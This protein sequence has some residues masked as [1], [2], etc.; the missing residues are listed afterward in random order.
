MQVAKT[1]TLSPAEFPHLCLAP[2]GDVNGA[3]LTVKPCDEDSVVFKYSTK[4]GKL[5][6]TNNKLCID[7]KDGEK[8]NGT[9]AQLWGCYTCNKNQVFD[10]HG[11]TANNTV[12][13]TGSDYC[14]DLT[15]GEGCEG[16]P[17]QLWRCV[18]GNTNQIWTVTEVHEEKCEDEASSGAAET[19][20]AAA[21]EEPAPAPEVTARRRH[22]K[23]TARRH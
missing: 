16:T 4:S 1:Y 17:V 5:R 6:N 21:E 20:A 9:P 19:Y 10:F 12:Q 18:P 14:L 7:V 11:T 3:G 8:K 23:D 22:F 13:W 2:A 15:D